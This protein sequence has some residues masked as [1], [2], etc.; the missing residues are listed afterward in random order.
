M[1][2]AS[3][4]SAA[5]ESPATHAGG[6]IGGEESKGQQCCSHDSKDRAHDILLHRM[7]SASAASPLAYKH[8]TPAQASTRDTQLRDQPHG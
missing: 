7:R 8:R 6:G 1:E 4:E 3:M 2:A 5:A